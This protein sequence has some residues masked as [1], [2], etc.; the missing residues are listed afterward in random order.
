MI[1]QAF[2]TLTAIIVCV[3]AGVGAVAALAVVFA[4]IN[5]E[6]R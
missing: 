2:L 3:G 4:A 1:Q 5:G 6:G